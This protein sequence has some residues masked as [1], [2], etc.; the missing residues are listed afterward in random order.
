MSRLFESR[1]I[2]WFIANHARYGNIFHHLNGI[3]GMATTAF[4]NDWLL[5]TAKAALAWTKLLA[6]D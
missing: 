3:F 2:A 5:G 6:M 4:L 1:S